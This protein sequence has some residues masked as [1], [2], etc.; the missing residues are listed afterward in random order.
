[1]HRSTGVFGFTTQELHVAL[2]GCR[3]NDFL[4]LLER[5]RVPK[6]VPVGSAHLV[7][8]YFTRGISQ[9]AINSG[10]EYYGSLSRV[11]ELASALSWFHRAHLGLVCHR[12]GI[13]IAGSSTNMHK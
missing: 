6:P 2:L 7:H 9:T 13:K 12:R 10:T 11:M 4:S 3:F 8:E 1:M 5:L